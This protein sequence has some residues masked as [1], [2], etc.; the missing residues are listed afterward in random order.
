[1]GPTWGPPGSCQPQMGPMLA[2]WT[3]LLGYPAWFAPNSYLTPSGGCA[4]TDAFIFT[5]SCCRFSTKHLGNYIQPTHSL[6]SHV[7]VMIWR[8]FPHY[9][10]FIRGVRLSLVDSI[11][12]EPVLQ[13]FD[14]TLMLAQ[15]NC[16]INTQA[17][18]DLRRHD[19]HVIYCNIGKNHTSC[20][21]AVCHCVYGRICCAHVSIFWNCVIVAT[22]M[23]IICLVCKKAYTIQWYVK[24]QFNQSMKRLLRS[25]P[26]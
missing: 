22:W 23:D 10:R 12:K 9:W 4:L 3:L 19:A 26:L 18:G 5:F 7:G 1:M 25:F 15:I 6:L 16:W 21:C 8:H 24:W 13:T 14:V 20:D 2:P 11:H 17:A